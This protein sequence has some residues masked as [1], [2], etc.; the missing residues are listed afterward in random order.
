MT[1]RGDPLSDNWIWVELV[2]VG[3]ADGFGAF[4]SSLH[5]VDERTAE[6]GSF[7]SVQ[8]EGGSATW[9]ANIVLQLFRMLLCLQNHLR[10]PLVAIESK[11]TNMEYDRE[12]REGLVYS[13]TI[14]LMAAN[15][16][17]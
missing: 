7:E 3:V 17:D 13:L 2:V 6:T 15:R 4:G 11:Q 16:F 14:M 5:G 1:S 8:R 12:G 9:R 10:R